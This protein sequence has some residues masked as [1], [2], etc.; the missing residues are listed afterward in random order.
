MFRIVSYV[1]SYAITQVNGNGQD[2]FMDLLWSIF[3]SFDKAKM[4]INKQYC[5]AWKQF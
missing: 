3:W 5:V 1:I 4:V 2:V